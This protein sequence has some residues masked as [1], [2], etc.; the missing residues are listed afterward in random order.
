MATN[1][2]VCN[3]TL[4]CNVTHNS[5][6]STHEV[7]HRKGELHIHLPSAQEDDR[8][9]QTQDAVADNERNVLL[10]ANGGN[11]IVAEAAQLEAGLVVGE[12]EVELL[13]GQPVLGLAQLVHQ[14]AKKVHVD[15][16]C[17]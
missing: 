17:R 13:L 16:G 5:S 8:W 15:L 4:F 14:R 6:S 1:K 3:L 10:E 9:V 11:C 12:L 2:C 7:R